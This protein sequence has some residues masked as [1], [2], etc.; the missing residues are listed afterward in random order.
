MTAP[1]RT[2]ARRRNVE[3]LRLALAM[4]GGVSLAVWIGGAVSEIERMRRGG[5]PTYSALLSLAG[6]RP[7]VI[8]DVLSGAS[9]GGLN[10]AVYAA[11]Q[12]H[13]LD[14]ARLRDL[15]I[16]VGD[17]EALTRA[18]TSGYRAEDGARVAGT[19]QADPRD[20][21]SRARRPPSLLDG[22]GYF[23]VQ[24][25]D[26][27][28]RLYAER[29]Q[30]RADGTPAPEIR[31]ADRVELVLTATL[32][33]SVRTT[34][35]LNS[36]TTVEDQRSS[37]QFRFRHG[38]VRTDFHPG[39][40][41][42]EVQTS[43]ARL[44]MAARTT[45]SFP[46]AFEPASIGVGLPA[47]RRRDVADGLDFSGTFEA[48]RPP[49]AAGPQAVIDGGVLDNI[50]VSAA[51]R[52]VAHAPAD[53]PTARRLVYM[54]PSPPAVRRSAGAAPPPDLAA[55]GSAATS[56]ARKPST[57]RERIASLGSPRAIKAGVRTMGARFGQESLLADIDELMDVNDVA[58]RRRLATEAV[59]GE[60]LDGNDLGSDS[61]ARLR[62]NVDRRAHELD[63]V[64]A[65]VASRR[66]L[67]ALEHPEWMPA[68][69]HRLDRG[70]LDALEAAAGRSLRTVLCEQIC[71]RGEGGRRDVWESAV[72]LEEAALVI[73]SWARDLER[74][75]SDEPG[76][77]V[78]EVTTLRDIG[79]VKAAGYRARAIAELMEWRD[80]Q[81]WVRSAAQLDAE[82][83]ADVER[84]A[85]A[86]CVDA[87]WTVSALVIDSLAGA[88]ADD[89]KFRELMLALA[90]DAPPDGPDLRPALWEQM[91]GLAQRLAAAGPVRGAPSERQPA[92]VPFRILEALAV[93]EG[94][95]DLIGRALA[96]ITRLVVPLQLVG[97]SENRIEFVQLS[98]RA[99]TPLQPRFT[100]LLELRQQRSAR[101]AEKVLS[102]ADHRLADA[103]LPAGGLGP[104]D[105][106]RPADKLCGDELGNFAA[107]LSARWRAN[108]WMW[109]RMDAAAT[110]V[111]LLV[112][113]ERLGI[114]AGD[115][116][117]A[118]DWAKQAV[119]EPD[120]A[121]HDAPAWATHFGKLWES[122]GLEGSLTEAIGSD[123]EDVRGAAAADLRRVVLTRLHEEILASELPV[124]AA[125]P[126][127]PDPAWAP[128][129]P[130]GP[131]ALAAQIETYDVGIE[132]PKALGDRRR[133][134]IGMR[135]GLVAFGALRPDGASPIAILGRSAVSLLKPVYLAGV[136][137]AL[138]V[139]RG[140]FVAAVAIAAL[141]ATFWQRA[142]DWK[143][144]S[145]LQAALFVVGAILA[146][147]GL[148]WAGRDANDARE[149][150][151]RRS[152]WPGRL[153]VVGGALG[154]LVL[155]N[156]LWATGPRYAI[157]FLVAVGL[158][159]A[160]LTRWRDQRS[161]GLAGRTRDQLWYPATIVAAAAGVIFGGVLPPENRPVQDRVVDSAWASFRP[162][163]LMLAG[164]AIVIAIAGTSWM[165]RWHRVGAVALTA[166]AYLGTAAPFR[167]GDGAGEWPQAVRVLAVV[168]AIA[169]VA[170][171]AMLAAVDAVRRERASGMR[172]WRM[173]LGAALTVALP[174]AIAAFL[175][176]RHVTSPAGV[177][178]TLAICVAAYTLT[179]YATFADVLN[180]RPGRAPLPSSEAV[181]ADA[182][183]AGTE[184]PAVLAPAGAPAN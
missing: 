17:I 117:Q 8:V 110:L 75:M 104:E 134:G 24:L 64:G 52:A 27:L 50:P 90:D 108:D 123:D 140:L 20:L 83:A 178:A 162:A 175:A 120:H 88:L 107:F 156:V 131:D 6:Y 121:A 62:E 16:R 54:H 13:G 118:V 86:Q 126:H 80:L 74:S 106:L 153:L 151:R 92:T 10:G 136:F 141:Q 116:S 173:W 184:P 44:A 114:A 33:E 109:G 143:A 67:E 2:P 21:R 138:S 53:G 152:E 93:A 130:I 165:R 125:T 81:Q 149:R 158:A 69:D 91:A 89:A 96:G 155:L 71:A 48:P 78:R 22:D 169:V 94:G 26:E 180:P 150:R 98:G 34:V 182:D 14:I 168:A 111:D 45:S 124:V 41:E 47:S 38:Q 60:Y 11:S 70:A 12:V 144:P 76:R 164:A 15:W 29:D 3:E 84:W 36:S 157:L 100:R 72:N 139:R 35:R 128:A 181:S 172:S 32:F 28:R 66:I 39:E 137:S 42:E 61:F 23:Y 49:G 112:T 102:N 9:A 122:S 65:D 5:H 18:T 115:I 113:P 25:R 148:W 146:G 51:I 40:N 103:P 1:E 177:W 97:P 154:A 167:I 160:A 147:I 55:D 133:I 170:G 142:D 171:L 132:R 161:Q 163:A 58:E 145:P 43:L 59:F 68:D 166:G 183:A 37:A 4:R 46:F 31:A 176:T 105:P 129:P 30:P 135:L 179:L 19:E 174:V 119:V 82:R 79:Q 101:E 73:V 85:A 63:K 7:Q 99:P 56:S 87:P 95:R 159:W 57:L 127:E 77:D